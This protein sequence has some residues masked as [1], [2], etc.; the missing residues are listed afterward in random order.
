MLFLYMEIISTTNARKQLS[1]I[2][3]RIKYQKKTIT[4]GRNNKPEVLIVPITNHNDIPI[5]E[6]NTHSPS[7]DFLHDEEDVYIYIYIYI[8]K[9]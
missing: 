4:L 7:F 2:V 5:T 9:Q 3:N 1:D 8:F 6:I